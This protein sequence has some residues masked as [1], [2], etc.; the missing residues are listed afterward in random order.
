[1]P[2]ILSFRIEA[3]SNLYLNW[4]KDQVSG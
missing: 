1:V 4:V 2:E 3:G